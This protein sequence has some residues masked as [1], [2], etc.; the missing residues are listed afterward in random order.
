[1]ENIRI[2]QKNSID[3]LLIIEN[4]N[5]R[6][7]L[8]TNLNNNEMKD[9]K[10]EI[11]KIN[12][13]ITNK[14]IISKQISK[15]SDIDSDILLLILNYIDIGNVILNLL[16]TNKLFNNLIKH[17][18]NNYIILLYRLDIIDKKYVF[19]IDNIIPMI[20]IPKNIFT[21]DMTLE[22][23]FYMPIH[24]TRSIIDLNINCLTIHG[25]HPIISSYTTGDICMIKLLYK[26]GI[27]N[28]SIKNSN[29]TN[30]LYEMI[31]FYNDR[32]PNYIKPELDKS[33][34]KSKSNV[35]TNYNYNI[36]LN[37]KYIMNRV[38]ILYNII[39]ELFNEKAYKQDYI[40]KIIG[41]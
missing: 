15:L 24:N 39:D 4:I 40:I 31:D 1:M 3:I 29:V 9:L 5:K 32:L 25:T 21:D 17:E 30:K 11:N 10:L 20:C 33:I 7:E 28:Y 18:Y 2:N 37:D 35:Y 12:N 22:Q 38:M 41:L 19:N 13:I 14:C 36:L 16:L 34:N 26:I 23:I 6:L 8:R 27:V